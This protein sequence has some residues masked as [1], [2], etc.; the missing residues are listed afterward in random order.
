MAHFAEVSN[1]GFVTRVL[2][3]PD[4]EDFRGEDFLAKDLCLGGRWVKCSYN[5]NVRKNFPGAGYRYD[6]VKDVFIPPRPVDMHGNTCSSF[7]LDE[8]RCRWV[9]PTPAPDNGEWGWDESTHAWQVLPP[10][11]SA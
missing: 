1:D 3:V 11:C 4:S 5:G 10:F 2:V 8:E 6:E 9:P 7:I